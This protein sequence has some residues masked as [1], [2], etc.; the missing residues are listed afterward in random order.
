MKRFVYLFTGIA[1]IL[2]STIRCEKESIGTEEDGVSSK[3]AKKEKVNVIYLGIDDKYLSNSG[4]NEKGFMITRDIQEMFFQLNDNLE[5]IACGGSVKPLIS[6]DGKL[7]RRRRRMSIE[8]VN[9]SKLIERHNMSLHD[10]GSNLVE[11]YTSSEKSGEM[12][13][14]RSETSSK[15]SPDSL[16]SRDTETNVKIDID[17]IELTAVVE[18]EKERSEGESSEKDKMD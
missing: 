5:N 14:D 1:F 11:M 16:E 8:K 6:G 10:D 7:L 2:V 4:M 17:K 13:E 12:S 3:G 9:A 15:P 18:G